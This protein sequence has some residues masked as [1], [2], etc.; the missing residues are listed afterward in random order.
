MIFLKQ[1]NSSI[2]RSEY[3]GKKKKHNSNKIVFSN[4]VLLSFLPC[5]NLIG[6]NFFST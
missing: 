6:S 5:W 4:R 1:L 3:T 2:T